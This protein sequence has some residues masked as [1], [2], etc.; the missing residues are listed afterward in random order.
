MPEAPEVTTIVEELNEL[1]LGTKITN[2]IVN[3]S[4]AKSPIKPLSLVDFKELTIGKKITSVTRE[5]K[6]III[7]LDNKTHLLIHLLMTGQLWVQKD[8]PLYHRVTFVLSSGQYLHLADKSTWVTIKVFDDKGLANYLSSRNLGMDVLSKNFV[9]AGFRSLLSTSRKIHSLLLDQKVVS[10][11]GNIYVNEALF[12]ARIKP[13]RKAN[14]LTKKEIIALYKA[15]KKILKEAVKH[16]G[17]TFSDYRTPKGNK[18]NHQNY[19]KVFKRG[20][21]ECKLCGKAIQ[22]D[23]VS[24]RSV[25]YCNNCQ[26]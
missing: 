3:T 4:K 15:V 5:G 12:L 16:G 6:M 22:R 19:L 7:T 18:G 1:V 26:L 14:S 2:V 20:G 10:G 8:R 24:G 17:T 21:Q 13:D 25:F 23:K 11:L 9:L